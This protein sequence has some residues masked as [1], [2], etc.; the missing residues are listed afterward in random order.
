MHD[1]HGAHQLLDIMLFFSLAAIIASFIVSG[2]MD[3]FTGLITIISS[4]A[5]LTMD[6][7]CVGGIGGA[8]L[9]VGL[10]GLACTGILARS[11]A[12]LSG[13][14][15]MAFFLTI[16]FSFFGMDI[17]N[18]WPCIL[19]TL[20][21]TKSVRM[22]FASQVNTAL[23][24]TSLSP[25]VNE[26]MLR[27]PLF[28][29]LPCE[30]V[31]RVIAALI[32]GVSAGFLM[33]I[34]CHHSPNLHKGYSLYNG[35][36]V[37]GYIGILLFAVLYTAM[38][39]PVPTNNQIGPSQPAAVNTFMIVVCT[40][41]IAA[42][43]YYNGKSFKGLDKLY[44]CSGY[45]TDFTRTLGVPLT[46]VHLGLF[47][48]FITL[49]YNLIGATMNGP[50]LGSI[51]CLLAVAPCGGHLMNVI[52]IMCGYSIASLLFHFQLNTPA[53]VVGF[54][55]ACSLCQIAGHFGA[56]SGV[57][58]GL[59]HASLVSTIVNFHAGLCLYNGGFTSGIC[60]IILVPILETYFVPT[61]RLH[62]IPHII[63]P[64]DRHLR[65]GPNSG[66][67]EHHTHGNNPHP[68]SHHHKH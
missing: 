36:A 28:T 15:L 25:F 24:A 60:A 3:T 18:I 42:G 27:Y 22:P 48:L 49:Y 32:V 13:V 65:H 9:N 33:P 62:L 57:L 47:G 12:K 41:A 67:H 51:I 50:T 45:R 16:G 52:P 44:F 7:F 64:K 26:M 59:L 11:H 63:H 58:A 19:G 37:A 30:G 53:I 31:L 34:L 68:I 6:A 46:V 38:N 8:F 4:P 5:Q 40:I 1:R 43:W 66:P 10:V 2:P 17:L 61:D 29:G 23:F 54:S 35:A 20:L 56:I 14:S 21:Y 39:I 55:F